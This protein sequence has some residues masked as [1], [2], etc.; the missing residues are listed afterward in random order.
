MQTLILGGARS[1]K[2]RIAEQRCHEWQQR[3][4]G[5]LVYLATG[6]G[7]DDEMQARIAHHQALREAGP[8]SWHLVEEPL[9]LAERLQEE[10]HPS[11]CILVDCLTLWLNNC[12]YQHCWPE[13]RAALFKWLPTLRA[14]LIFVSNEVG[15][16][17]IPL[18][19]E[20]RHF[21]DEAGRLHQELARV[22]DRVEFIVAGLPMR[23]K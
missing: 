19:A 8:E 12:L 4:Q 2:S 3:E 23:L 1:G 13:Q 21:V 11:R 6:T 17:I 20:T 16:G 7:L 10:D 14:E 9:K 18:G 22:C 15:Q 5:E